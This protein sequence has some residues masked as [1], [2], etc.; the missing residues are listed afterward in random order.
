MADPSIE[1]LARGLRYETA[2]QLKTALNNRNPIYVA[3]F[4]N[5][6][7]ASATALRAATATVTTARTTTS[8]SAGGVAALAAYPR[9]IVFTTAGST[10]S[11][12]PATATITGT[13]VDGNALTETVTLAQTATT[14]TSTK[15]FATITSIVEAA[16]DGT[17]ATIAIGI[18]TALGLPKK[19][20]SRAGAVMV[21]R[22]V[23]AG[24]FVTNGTYTSAASAPPYGAY[25]PNTAADGSNDYALVY[26][27]DLS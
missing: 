13:D 11:D 5:A 7:A 26:E 25:T 1:A 4:T 27:L 14:A 9:Q 19:A 2:Q 17:G 18:G 6:A 15:C 12:A 21:L 24:S 16:G 23:S 10:A 22:E 20:K 8:F 3:E